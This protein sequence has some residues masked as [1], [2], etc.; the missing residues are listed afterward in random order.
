MISE[1]SLEG[2]A[3]PLRLRVVGPRSSSC[4]VRPTCPHSVFRSWLRTSVASMWIGSEGVV[5]D[6]RSHSRSSRSAFHSSPPS[7]ATIVFPAFLSRSSLHCDA[8]SVHSNM[9]G[10][11]VG[12]CLASRQECFLFR[13]WPSPG[14][15]S[16]SSRSF[17]VKSIFFEGVPVLSP[18]SFLRVSSSFWFSTLERILPISAFNSLFC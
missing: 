14:A 15:L 5:H 11:R 10:I 3:R 9:V 7:S 18:K 6:A 16:T 12:G 13:T 4:P 17:F 8:S 2:K 1:K